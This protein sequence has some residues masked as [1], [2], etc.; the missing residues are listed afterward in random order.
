MK[1]TDPR[2]LVAVL[3][4]ADDEGPIAPILARYAR[5]GVKIFLVIASDGM[6]GVGSTAYLARPDSNPRGEELVRARAAEAHCAA[7]VLGVQPPIHLDFPDGK[8]GDY[9]GDRTLIYRL[10]ERLAQE[11]A[12]LRPD[13]LI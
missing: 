13:V 10:T 3:A 9:P 1:S 4:H 5:E 7:E 11:L 12:R 6:Q 2:T 8:L